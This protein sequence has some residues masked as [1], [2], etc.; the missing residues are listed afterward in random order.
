[1]KALLLLFALATSILPA[2]AMEWERGRRGNN[3]EDRRYSPEFFRRNGRAS[4]SWLHDNLSQ[5][6]VPVFVG[7]P[8]RTGGVV[9]I[10]FSVPVTPENTSDLRSTPSS[11]H[12][13]FFLRQHTE[14]WNRSVRT[15]H[16]MYIIE[17]N[18]GRPG[19]R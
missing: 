11:A 14:G 2:A 8:S 15:A 13:R 19:I 10:A 17:M 4:A 6:R 12:C 5:S 7:G 3:V 16:G 1:M 18:C 9:R